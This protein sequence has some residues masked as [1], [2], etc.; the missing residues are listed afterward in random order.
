MKKTE[1]YDAW[2]SWKLIT[3]VRT[4]VRTDGRES[5]GLRD[6]RILET[7]NREDVNQLT[8]FT[9]FDCYFQGNDHFRCKNN[10]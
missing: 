1:K 6:S 10:T 9:K 7:K 8:Y 4:Y 5:I 3:H 2:I